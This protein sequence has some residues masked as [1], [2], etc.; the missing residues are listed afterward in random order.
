[1]RTWWA[2]NVT[3]PGT[4][5]VLEVVSVCR[6]PLPGPIVGG[7]QTI[8]PGSPLLHK[9][10]WIW[11]VVA[12]VNTLR[13]VIEVMHGGAVSTLE[14]PCILAEDMYEA[15]IAARTKLAKAIK[16]RDDATTETQ[17]TLLVGDIG[18]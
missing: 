8:L 12:D 16:D 10:R 1:V 5:F 15:L 3:Q 7:V 14:V 13:Y 18:N 2:L 6:T 9:D 11:R 17:K 4:R